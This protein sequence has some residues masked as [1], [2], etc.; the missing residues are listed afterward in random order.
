MSLE[1]RLIVKN[2]TA[3]IQEM[4]EDFATIT[5][6]KIQKLFNFTKY[7]TEVSIKI[8]DFIIENLKTSRF[9]KFDNKIINFDQLIEYEYES[10]EIL[11]VNTQSDSEICGIVIPSRIFIEEDYSVKVCI[12]DKK[13]IID[14]EC[15]TKYRLETIHCSK[16]KESQEQTFNSKFIMNVFK[17]NLNNFCKVFMKKDFP[18]CFEF[19]EKRIFIAPLMVSL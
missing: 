17:H 3:T 11:E 2:N 12:E 15:G 8:D 1:C 4:N 13:L 6:Y 10:G 18:I 16:S 7:K 14:D 19:S 5:E 9:I